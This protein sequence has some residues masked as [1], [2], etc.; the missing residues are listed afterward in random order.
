MFQLP[1]SK[2]YCGQIETAGSVRETNK[3]HTNLKANDDTINVS[4]IS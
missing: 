3:V 4:K 2:G 1:L